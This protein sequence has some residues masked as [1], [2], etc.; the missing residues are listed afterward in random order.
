[1][2]TVRSTRQVTTSANTAFQV[3]SKSEHRRVAQ[4]S[5]LTASTV[6]YIGDNSTVTAS[7]GHYVPVYV[8]LFFGK[9]GLDPTAELWMV[10]STG[11]KVITIYEEFTHDEHKI[12][13][14]D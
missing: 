10:E 6:A 5:V 1:M 9:G 13:A 14:K 4:I 12:T 8:P 7:T 2:V 11:S 3:W